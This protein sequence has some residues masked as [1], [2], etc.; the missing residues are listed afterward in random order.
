MATEEEAIAHDDA[1]RSF[2]ATRSKIGLNTGEDECDAFDAG[3]NSSR[4]FWRGPNS[5]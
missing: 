4:R 3:W 5:D 1:L 2:A